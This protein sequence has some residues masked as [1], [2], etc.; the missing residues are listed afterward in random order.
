[1][2]V[3]RERRHYKRDFIDFSA[4]L[5]PFPPHFTWDVSP[6]ILGSYPDEEYAE[7]K[8]RIGKVFSRKPEEIA[9]G[10][11]SIELIRVFC[12]A[13]FEKGTRFFVQNPTFGEYTLS[14]CLAGGVPAP[15]EKS[16]V[17]FLCN[18]NNPTGTLQTRSQV[19]PSF[20]DIESSGGWMFLDEAFIDLADPAESCADVRSPA[21]FVSRSLTK[22]FA[23]PGL[24]MGYGF[25]PVDLV[26]RMEILRPP[27]SVNVYAEA[28][29]FQAFL[30]FDELAASR[31]AIH[32]ERRFLAAELRERGL[33]YTP[34]DANYLLVALPIPATGF[35]AC[36]AAQGMLV[37]DCT[38]FG[39]PSSI[40]IAVRRHEEN[41]ELLEA[42]SRCLP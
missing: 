27:W 20:R 4:N 38:S 14:A 21:L 24:R 28:F 6:E 31:E 36:L 1:G 34:S 23:V 39:L 26:E 37:R 17:H 35:S 5:N 33:S 2:K 9:V 11:G 29:A 42:L 19:I 12:S 22:A 18:P 8:E 25:G 41:L 16:R 40:R 15:T 32:Q 13:V 10:N 3:R 30:H 7:L